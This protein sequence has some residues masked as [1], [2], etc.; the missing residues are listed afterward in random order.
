LR[1]NMR[2]LLSGADAIGARYGCSNSDYATDAA[3][4]Q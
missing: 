2:R 1:K 4:V 3:W